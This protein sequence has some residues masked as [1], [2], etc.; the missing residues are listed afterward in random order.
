[1]DLVHGK[2]TCGGSKTVRQTIVETIEA[3]RLTGIKTTDF[4]NFKEKFETY[5][6]LIIGRSRDPNI[7]IPLTSYGNSISKPMLTMFVLA[8]WSWLPQS[9]M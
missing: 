7:D 6:R 5:E 8:N 9:I 1:M 3:P 2:D 4:V